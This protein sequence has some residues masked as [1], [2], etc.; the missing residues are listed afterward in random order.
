MIPVSVPLASAPADLSTQV[1][2]NVGVAV[3]VVATIVGLLLI[4][5]KP[6]RAGR[7]TARLLDPGRCS[8][9][10]AHSLNRAVTRIGRVA[11]NDIVIPQETVSAR[12]A[13]IRAAGGVF[14]LRDLKSGNGTYLNGQRLGAEEAP[15]SN[16]DRVRFDMYEFLFQ[17]EGESRPAGATMLRE[18]DPAEAATLAKPDCARHAGKVAAGRCARCRQWLCR[19][20]LGGDA[21]AAVCEDCRRKAQ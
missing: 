12:H 3:F 14:R 19:E 16:G 20:C 4:R 5:R 11:E 7:T 8:G 17:A 1:A 18:A 13:E 9:S 15:L 6:G 21:S 10:D 2:I